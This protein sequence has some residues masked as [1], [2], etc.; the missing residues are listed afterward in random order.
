M[1]RSDVSGPADRWSV[2]IDQTLGR[3]LSHSIGRVQLCWS[4]SET[5]LD[6]IGRYF[7]VRLVVLP[8][9]LVMLRVLLLTIN[10]EVRA[11]GHYL[12]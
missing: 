4:R 12:A 3:V 2:C 7:L 1:S 11:S 9:C 6:M 8:S 5:F 10:S